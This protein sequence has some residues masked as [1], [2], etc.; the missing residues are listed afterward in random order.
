[1]SIAWQYNGKLAALLGQVCV[2]AHNGNPNA[3]AHP[4]DA[5]HTHTQTILH[6]H[7]TMR[8]TQ[9]DWLKLRQHPTRSETGVLVIARDTDV[10]PH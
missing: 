10:A 2:C 4:N 7:S 9:K 3:P 8:K 6:A 5:K 1:M